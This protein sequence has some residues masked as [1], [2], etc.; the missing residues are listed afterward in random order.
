[1]SNVFWI[2]KLKRGGYKITP[3]RQEIINCIADGG[4]H[5]SAEEIYQ[6]VRQ[7]FAN[8]SLDTVYRNLSTLKKLGI[9]A[10]L[11]FADGKTRYEPVKEDYHHHHLICIKCGGSEEL[12]FCPLDF[13]DAAMLKEKGFMVARHNFE[14]F[15]YCSKCHKKELL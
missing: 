7:K 3:Q 11:N 13:L 15:G 4:K 5:F 10:E 9:I 8:I 6:T 12:D 14:I 2:D 1:M